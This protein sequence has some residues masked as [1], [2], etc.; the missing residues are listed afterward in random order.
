MRRLPLLYLAF[1][2]LA[3]SA[4]LMLTACGGGGGDEAPGPGG[5]FSVGGTVA[6]LPA[7]ALVLANGADEV[8]VSANGPFAFPRSYPAG[9]GYQVTLKSVAGL[10]A[11]SCAV[12]N[13]SGTVQG[14]VSSVVVQCT[15]TP[16][17][18]T[19]GDGLT[20]AEELRWGTSVRIAD[21]DGDG[22]SDFDEVVTKAFDPAP[23]K[24][25]QFNPRI[26]D[27]P[28]IT[29]QMT[30]PPDL[31]VNY[32]ESSG[33]SRTTGV[34]RSTESARTTTRSHTYEASV[35]A[36]LSSSVGFSGIDLTGSVTA[37]TTVQES[38]S[39]TAEQSFENRTAVS[40]MEQQTSEAGVTKSHGDLGVRMTVHNRG[41]QTVT[42]Q[43]LT[44]SA[45][46]VDATDPSRQKFIAGLDYD[47]VNAF[48]AFEIAPN[49]TSNEL[50]F[51]AAVPLGR[52][53]EVLRNSRNLI[54]QPATWNIRDADGRSYTHN[55]TNV[56]A[57]A[58]HVVID[59]GDRRPIESFYVSTLDPS[60]GADG[61]SAELAMN[62]ILR[63]PFTATSGLTSVREVAADDR[64]RGRWMVI[65]N[66]PGADGFSR[67]ST[68]Y[69]ARQAAYRMADLRVAKNEVLHLL[70][71]EDRDGDGLGSREEF[72]HGTSDS[73]AD[74]DGDGLSDHD[75]IKVGWEI[76][77][78]RDLK[79]RVYSDPHRADADNDA[80]VDSLE[81][82]RGTH[83]GKRDTDGNGILDSQ[84]G[85]LGLAAMSESSFVPMDATGLV[86]PAFGS[87]SLTPS[88]ATF[89]S[90]RFCRANA[91]LRTTGAT[92]MQLTGAF[93]STP[94]HGAT[95]AFWF[96][97]DPTLPSGGW[98]LYEHRPAGQNTADQ[99]MWLYRDGMTAFGDGFDR[100]SVFSHQQDVAGKI[101][102][103]F[104]RWHLVTIVG[105]E[106]VIGEG[107]KRFSVYFD[108]QLY[109][110]RR[111][112]T[113]LVQFL[114]EPWF[115]GGTSSYAVPVQ[116]Y[117]GAFDD[118]RFFPR[119]L[120]A[121]EVRTLFDG[122]Q[123]PVFCP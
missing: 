67:E 65:H 22:L 38:M 54:V 18:D 28:Q 123:G 30:A 68:V 120:D 51:K 36:E 102:L 58:A 78:T 64:V 88:G 119:A 40:R 12:F 70:Y 101:A 19:D 39:W 13:G 61:I 32:T 55:L 27:V 15:A 9:T 3:T 90:D 94:S 80:L 14:N 46:W 11:N 50:P 25:F 83:P 35:S 57:R 72:V 112:S 97:A 85:S 62:D 110:A 99:F 1:T 73:V 114:M 60:T 106:E 26:A 76:P 92:P 4:L 98:N 8:A 71:V 53:L 81:R 111:H 5:S 82:A 79:R 7:G 93:R 91:A 77:V 113:T 16:T 69:D 103:E 2:L 63:I 48:P 24:N 105:E 96:K 31:S 115:F 86:D 42:L 107:M 84:D 89:T 49:Q 34:E 23:G 20:D 121:D 33:T 10:P 56:L 122:Q 104:A 44:V 75:E 47:S 52:T 109:A 6:G 100:H 59:Y 41:F 43:N 117:R 66:V 95:M 118:L 45:Y 37:T 108:G 74:T 29:V 21:T 87:T 17:A 116:P